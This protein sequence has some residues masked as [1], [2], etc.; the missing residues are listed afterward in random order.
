VKTST[1][2]KVATALKEN[3]GHVWHVR[4][5][6]RE[7]SREV[8]IAWCGGYALPCCGTDVGQLGAGGALWHTMEWFCVCKVLALTVRGGGS[9]GR[10]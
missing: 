8:L 10:M 5:V 9:A 6:E 7:D 3:L 4:I 2:G 1:T